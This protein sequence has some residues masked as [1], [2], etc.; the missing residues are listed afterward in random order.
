MVVF[1]SNNDTLLHI[2]SKNIKFHMYLELLLTTPE[3]FIGTLVGLDTACS[4][5]SFFSSRELDC[6]VSTARDSIAEIGGI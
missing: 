3:L 2:L 4:I 1:D 6:L 5:K